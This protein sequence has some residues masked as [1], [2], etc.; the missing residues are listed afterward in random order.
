MQPFVG[1]DADSSVAS[2]LQ[3]AE[4]RGGIKSFWVHGVSLLLW[5]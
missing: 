5:V 2:P 1:K 4:T 3:A